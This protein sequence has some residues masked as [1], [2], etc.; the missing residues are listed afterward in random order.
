M[1]TFG[2]ILLIFM[3]VFGMVGALFGLTW[4]RWRRDRDRAPD[5]WKHQ[6]P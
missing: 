2:H 6:P 3:W 5:Y 1:T 4:L